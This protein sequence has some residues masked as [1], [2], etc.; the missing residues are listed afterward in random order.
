[1]NGYQNWFWP[2][3]SWWKLNKCK[4]FVVSTGNNDWFWKKKKYYNSNNLWA[5]DLHFKL[6]FFWMSK[7]VLKLF[8]KSVKTSNGVV[9]NILLIEIQ[10]NNNILLL[11]RFS[12]EKWGP[13]ELMRWPEVYKICR[14][15]HRLTYIELNDL[16][17]HIFSKLREQ[18]KGMNGWQIQNNEYK[19]IFKLTFA[20]VHWPLNGSCLFICLYCVFHYWTY[21]RCWLMVVSKKP[22]TMWKCKLSKR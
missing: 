22:K 4:Q 12:K 1:L 2:P 9:W 17:S 5:I 16:Q 11:S 6:N 7:L 3:K 8:K 15:K 18:S 10:S 21:F 19:S 20:I 13:L 14:T